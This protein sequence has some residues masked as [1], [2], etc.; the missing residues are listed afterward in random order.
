MNRRASEVGEKREPITQDRG[1]H[2]DTALQHRERKQTPTQVNADKEYI[3]INK[4]IS[5]QDA[6]TR[7]GAQARYKRTSRRTDADACSL[8][9]TKGEQVG[10]A[11]GSTRAFL[12]TARASSKTCTGKLW[13]RKGRENRERSSEIGS[14]ALR[15]LNARSFLLPRPPPFIAQEGAVRHSIPTYRI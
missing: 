9:R 13:S 4:R 1:L 12:E 10:G 6:T 8:R 11:A 15:P 2:R 5:D 7:D 3:Y 14:A